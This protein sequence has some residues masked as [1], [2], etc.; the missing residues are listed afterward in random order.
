[1][2]VLAG[3][4]V[5]CLGLA[6]GGVALPVS[7]AAL[8]LLAVALVS[9]VDDQ[10]GV[11]PSVRF[12]VH[13]IAAGALL[14]SGAVA[15][16]RALGLP[17]VMA[18]P[19]AWLGIVW[20]I[21]L[22]NFMDGMDGLAGGM[23]AIGFA[24]LAALAGPESGSYFIL[25]LTIVGGATGFLVFNFPPARV[26]LGDVGSAPLGYLAAA[27]VLWGATT[28]AV[29]LPLGLLVFS[30]FIVDATVTLLR[31]GFAGE[32]VWQAHR[33]HYYQRLVLSGWSHRRT[34][35]WAYLL[36]LVVGGV[37]LGAGRAGP[38]AT[39]PALAV[40]AAGYAGLI[41]GL[42]LYLRRSRG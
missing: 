42:E 3:I 29:A 1:L 24:F 20:M 25:C 5:A 40:T 26:F 31:R 13:G 2:G 21:N 41:S 15:P 7:L 11:R 37:A 22:Y 9:L 28:G 36:M 18:A 27:C 33:T 30:P 19:L 39:W 35:L 34:V 10:R 16:D 32:P 4:G 23:A 12:V 6:T 8:G 17:I 38:W 14:L